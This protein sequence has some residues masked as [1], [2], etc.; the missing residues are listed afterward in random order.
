MSGLTQLTTVHNYYLIFLIFFLQGKNYVPSAGK[1]MWL[2]EEDL[3]NHHHIFFDDNIH[4]LEADSIVAIRSRETKSDAFAPLNGKETLDLHGVHL[5]R[6]PTHAPILNT[7]WFLEE[8][9]KC[10][11]AL[12]R[13]RR[14]RSASTSSSSSSLQQQN[15][16][17][18]SSRASKKQK[19]GDRRRSRGRSYSSSSSH[20]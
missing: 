10:E 4:N 20:C 19:T 7:S 15:S 18:H 14:A 17:S 16:G 12:A 5:V 11:A 13:R 3:D 1:P 2:T 9:D 6:V 8:I